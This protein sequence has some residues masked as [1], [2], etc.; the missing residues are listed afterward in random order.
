[1]KLLSLTRWV[2]DARPLAFCVRAAAL[3]LAMS[4]LS[5][6][7]PFDELITEPL[8]LLNAMLAH[9]ALRALGARTA[10]SGR[11]IQ[12]PSFSVEVIPECTG[13][14]VFLM[15]LAVTLAYPAS[16][17][18]KTRGVLG[19]AFLIFFLNQAR[20]VSLFILGENYPQVFEEAHVFV[21]QGIFITVVSF[22][23]YAWARKASTRAA[24]ANLQAPR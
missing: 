22:Y 3:L 20:L 8:I 19:G 2:L 12:S 16:W 23:W 10:L 1:M 18:A 15:V 13:V 11:F 4:L 6:T 5:I 21:W 17:R 14:F 9:Y 7:G 24:G